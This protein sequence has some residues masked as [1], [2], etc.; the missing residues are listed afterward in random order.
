MAGFQWMTLND[1]FK[2]IV[3]LMY[4]ENCVMCKRLATAVHHI[5][6]KGMGGCSL[7]IRYNPLNGVPVCEACHTRIHSE[8]GETTA[9]SEIMDRVPILKEQN[10]TTHPLAGTTDREVRKEM[11]AMMEMLT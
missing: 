6:P 9:R 2:T 3:L 11:K 10:H 5:E 1:L 7:N 8:V 4:G